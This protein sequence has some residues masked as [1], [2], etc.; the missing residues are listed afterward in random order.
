MMELHTWSHASDP[1]NVTLQAPD[2][3]Q[4]DYY[5]NGS[6]AALVPITNTW[7]W[8]LPR[9][10]YKVEF[11]G[12]WPSNPFW[13]P[14]QWRVTDPEDRVWILRTFLPTST[15]DRYTIARPISLTWRDGYQWTFTYDSS[16]RL[17]SITDTFGRTLAF[18]WIMQD[19]AAVG[20]TGTTLGATEIALPGGTKV[21]YTY[22]AVSAETIIVPQPDRLALVEQ[23]NA[24]NAVTESTTYHHEDSRYPFHIT[25]I[26]DG[27]GV[28][29]TNY[30]YDGLGRATLSEKVGGVDKVTVAYGD[31]PPVLT[32][33]VT[34]ALGKTATYKFQRITWSGS[35]DTKE[36]KF[37]GVDGAASTNCPASATAITYA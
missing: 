29:L 27:R 15:G 22:Q 34:N 17:T 23:V 16:A 36:V 5:K 8:T 6:N 2:G 3:S 21:R 1:N 7:T 19:Q 35:A 25:G 4:Y 13:A 10:D 20:G 14:T 31:T 30:A 37:I 28:R 12:T 33:T 32:R 9:S 26:T 18:T 24:S 11:V